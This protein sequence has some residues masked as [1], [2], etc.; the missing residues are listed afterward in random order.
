MPTTENTFISTA[1]QVNLERTAAT[2]EIPEKYR[3][4]LDITREP[5][6]DHAP[7]YY[8]LSTL[9]LYVDSRS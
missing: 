7:L 8:A 3:V 6:D 9:N 2:V 4:L 5:F 1:L